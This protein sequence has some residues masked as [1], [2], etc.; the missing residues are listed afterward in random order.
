M[1][2]CVRVRRGLVVIGLL[3]GVS[4]IGCAGGVAFAAP[5]A[6]GMAANSI[7]VQGKRRVETDTIL[8]YFK[9]AP[10]EHLDAAAIDAAL[11]ALYATGMFEDV[12]ISQSG[13]H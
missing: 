4:L 1:G 10:G 3:L 2:M 13:G 9:V 11:K 8:S 12:R 5:P 6:A 7:I